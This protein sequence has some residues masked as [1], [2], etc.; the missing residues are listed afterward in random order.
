MQKIWVL[1]TRCG[2]SDA[3]AYFGARS[4]GLGADCPTCGTNWQ[5]SQV[6]ASTVSPFSSE[7]LGD[8]STMD[9]KSTVKVIWLS[10]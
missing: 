9:K 3:Y 7:I 4:I 1:C 5:D 8:F 2:S 10:P 6:I